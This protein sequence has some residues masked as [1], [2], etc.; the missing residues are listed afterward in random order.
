MVNKVKGLVIER[1]KRKGI[2][3]LLWKEEKDDVLCNTQK[4]KHV[5]NV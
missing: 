4:Y 2:H 1:D 3:I 5:F